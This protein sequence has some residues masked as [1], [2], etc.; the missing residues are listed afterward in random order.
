MSKEGIVIQINHRQR[1]GGGAPSRRWL[2]G[3]GDEA[4]SRWA[5]FRNFFEKKAILIPWDHISHVF[6]A[7]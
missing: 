1:S 2:W 7:I 3:S 5:I 4:R 6:R